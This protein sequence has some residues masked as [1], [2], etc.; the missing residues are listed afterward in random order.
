MTSA[1]A[2]ASF[3]ARIHRG[4]VLRLTLDA[5]TLEDPDIDTRSKYVVVLSALLPDEQ[6]WFAICTSKEE[7]F[8]NH[9]HLQTEI[10][11]WVAGEYAWC[12]APVTIVDCS[13][14]YSIPMEKLE[15]L[16]LDGRLAFAGGIRP[17]HLQAIDAITKKSR[18]LSPE[19]KRWVVPW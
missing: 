16:Y 12:R 2:G 1:P 11:R 19:D 13:K 9:P 7:H 4:T 3:S 17:K 15:R 14:V 8:N 10:L 5:S 6:V 18:F